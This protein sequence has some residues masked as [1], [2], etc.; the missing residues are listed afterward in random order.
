MELPYIIPFFISFFPNYL[1]NYNENQNNDLFSAPTR[2][3]IPYEI[4]KQKYKTNQNLIVYQE[5]SI[6]TTLYS[7]YNNFIVKKISYLR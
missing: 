1:K 7:F 2:S 6:V 3:K 4:N 5:I